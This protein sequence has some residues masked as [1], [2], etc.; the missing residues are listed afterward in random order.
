M[1]KNNII[2]LL[3]VISCFLI[4]IIFSN[5]KCDHEH[6]HI[7]NLLTEI[8]IGINYLYLKSDDII[9]KIILIFF[10]S[11][12]VYLLFILNKTFNTLF[13]MRVRLNN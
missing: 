13:G 5:H 8:N 2:M 9:I 11:S 7:C 3:L 6:C 4:L 12:I 1:N 10:I